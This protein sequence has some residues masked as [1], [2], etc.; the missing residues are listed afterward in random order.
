MR[1][2]AATYATKAPISAPAT[3]RAKTMGKEVKGP[4]G[5]MTPAKVA[6]IKPEKPDFSPS[7]LFILSW[8]INC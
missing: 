3:Q 1:D 4:P 2:H 6:K 7:A 5:V 8:S